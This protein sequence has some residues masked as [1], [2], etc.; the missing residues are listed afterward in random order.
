MCFG[1][2]PHTPSPTVIPPPAPAPAVND[3]MSPELNITTGQVQNRPGSVPAFRNDLT[4]P[5]PN[6]GSADLNIPT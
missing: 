2:S 4:I 5:T 3:Q 1:G 6:R